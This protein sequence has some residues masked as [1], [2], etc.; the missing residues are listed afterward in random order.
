VNLVAEAVGS[1]AVVEVY[2]YSVEIQGAGYKE[3]VG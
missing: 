3:L 2:S 1:Q